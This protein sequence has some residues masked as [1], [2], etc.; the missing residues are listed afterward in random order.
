MAIPVFKGNTELPNL[1][2]QVAKHEATAYTGGTPDT[3]GDH[4]SVTADPYTIFNV[5]GV[6]IIYKIFGICNTNLVG[7]ATL[8]IGVTD[9][10]D[11]F[12]SVIF[13]DT[14]TWDAGEF[15][16]GDSADSTA[17]GLVLS[18]GLT[19]AQNIAGILLDGDV[20]NQSAIIETLEVANVT[21][22]QVDWYCI[23]AALEDGASIV[24][25]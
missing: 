3:H 16:D 19:K 24:S 25:A 20:T 5:S 13:A 9:N 18:A 7:A 8:D 2:Q 1:A 10:V 14:S 17:G 4:D 11:L 23:W 6:V 21:A 15:W 22:G 12:S